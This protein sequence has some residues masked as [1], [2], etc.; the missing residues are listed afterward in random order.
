MSAEALRARVTSPSN[1]SPDALV[2]ALDQIA[3]RRRWPTTA[4]VAELASRVRAVSDRYNDP[5]VAPRPADVDPAA[6]MLFFLPRDLPKAGEGIRELLAGGLIPDRPLRV[7]DLGAGLGASWLGVHAALLARGFA[8]VGHVRLVDVDGRAL[9]LATD[10]AAKL[11]PGTTVGTRVGTVGEGL[12]EAGGGWDLVLMGQVF[13]E[14]DRDRPAEERIHRHLAHWTRALAVCA[15]DGSVVVIEPALAPRTRH[16]QALKDAWIARGGR[17]SGPCLHQGACPLLV[18]P[19]DWCHEDR[20]SRLPDAL[21][22]VARAAGLRHE[23][24]TF[25]AVILRPD[26]AVPNGPSLRVVGAPARQKGRRELWLCGTFA[27]GVGAARMFRQ[28]RDTQ[29][30]EGWMEAH[31]GDRVLLEP[32]PKLAGPGRIPAETRVSVDPEPG[33]QAR[34]QL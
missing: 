14:L 24:T 13:S 8:G 28:D 23:R 34:K 22:P 3:A 16:L 17:V 25:L 1:L 33:I 11:A 9:E 27:D 12:A 20:A 31:R 30:E 29:P 32:L 2:A 19:K 18:H 5:E 4:Q 7:L 6:R 10:I 21:I 26:G 15:P